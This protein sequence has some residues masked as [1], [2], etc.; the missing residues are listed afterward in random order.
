MIDFDAVSLDFMIEAL[1]RLRKSFP[2]DIPV[3]C[4][5]TPSNAQ[6]TT[7]GPPGDTREPVSVYGVQKI[8]VGERPPELG[9]PMLILTSA[10]IGAEMDAAAQSGAILA[11]NLSDVERRA[12]ERDQAEERKVANMIEDIIAAHPA[13]PPAEDLLDAEAKTAQRS[14]PPGG[15][16]RWN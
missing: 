16:N 9:G 5:F 3:V 13:E 4:I 2:G 8:I 15:W 6:D 1:T 12:A 14:P 11:E 7:T 10:T